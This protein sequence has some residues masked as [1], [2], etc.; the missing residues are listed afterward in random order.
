MI[1]LTAKLFFARAENLHPTLHA[2]L[3][4]CQFNAGISE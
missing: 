4:L 2:V 3:A 1:R